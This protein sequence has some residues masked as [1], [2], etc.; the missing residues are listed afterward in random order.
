[1]VADIKFG[2]RLRELRKK[3]GL[4]LRELARKINVDFTYISKLENGQLPPPSEQVISRLA[5][6]LGADREGLIQISGRVPADIAGI[7]K[8]QARQAFGLKLK[9]L[10]K[11]AG[12]TQQEVAERTGIDATYLSKIEN[13]VMPPP[14]RGIVVLLAE[15][16][17]INKNE[18]IS[19]AGKTPVNI[20]RMR[21]KL[22]AGG[23]RRFSMPRISIKPAL[24]YRVALALFLVIAFSTSLWY[25]SPAPV[26][27]VDINIDNPASGILG[28]PY[29]FSVR[30]DIQDTDVLPVKSIDLRIYK[31]ISTG[32]YSVLFPDLPL[33]ATASATELKS[34]YGVGGSATITGTTGPGWVGGAYGYRTGYGYGYQNQTWETI[35]FG[36]GYG[37]GYGYGGGY[38]GATYIIYHVTWVPPAS[39]P[40]STYR[41]ETIVYGTSGDGS[42]AF[43]N[44]AVASFT[45][46]AAG[47]GGGTGGQSG[48]TTVTVDAQHLFTEDVTATSADGQVVVKASKGSKGETATGQ[49]LTSITIKEMSSPPA[50][51]AE[52]NR[53][54]LTYELRPDGAKF[55]DGVTLTMKY[56]PTTI[57]GGTLVMAYWNGSVWVDLEGPFQV[58]EVNH[59]VS[60]TI[61]H[62]TPFTIIE[63]VSP[64]AFTAS[65]LTISPAEVEIGEA[66]NIDVTITNTG[67]LSGTFDVV[68]KVDGTVTETQSVIIAGHESQE[69]SFEVSRNVAGTYTIGIE[70]LSGT[71][72]VK[73]IT[74]PTPTATP[75][76]TLTPTPTPTPTLTPS[77]TP[78]PTP[79]LA[80][81]ER[82]ISWALI[83]SIIAAIIIIGTFTLIAVSRRQSKP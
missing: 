62:F 39:W 2:S 15:V 34:Y 83:V 54:A 40:A 37:Y 75:T 1:V 76:P 20:A 7:L 67:D 9:E 13:G 60:A 48:V 31:E 8:N 68:L 58:D 77:P 82:G 73:A 35:T 33:P 42:K 23:R 46:A 64:A 59:T 66:A 3:A 72:T 44:D 24:V 28:S 14:T 19:L 74:E 27:A 5:E 29:S 32:I 36:Y 57:E 65:G 6:A 52:S 21:R 47:P 61:Y 41:I 78:T 69:V 53:V 63:Y 10:R 17:R 70:G 25:A 79:T 22:N 50:L 4:T 71:L 18:L 30:V 81:P 12:L 49:A 16:F 55:P 38:S 56:D 26:K 11:K 45:L 51:P 80:E 43:T